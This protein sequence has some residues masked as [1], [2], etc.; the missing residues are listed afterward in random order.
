[1]KN[2][3]KFKGFFF[4]KIHKDNEKSLKQNQTMR[5]HFNTTEKL[6]REP[7]SRSEGFL[8][9]PTEDGDGEL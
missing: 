5:R 7:H 3:H 8:E 9:P 2:N 6:L 1:M 4:K